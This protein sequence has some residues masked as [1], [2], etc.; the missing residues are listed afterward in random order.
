VSAEPE[1]DAERGRLR[2]AEPTL[3]VL[4]AHAAD[5]VGAVLEDGVVSELA[6]LR[7]AGVIRGGETHPM[8]AGALAAMVRPTLCTLRLSYDGRAMQGWASHDDAALLLPSREEIDERRTLLAVHPTLLPGALARL[9]GLGPRPRPRAEAPVPYED[10]ALE[11]V[12]RRWRLEAAWT[13]A[14]GA[15]GGATLEMV[16]TEGGIW[17]LQPAGDEPPLAW[18]VTPTFAWRQLVR[19]VMRRDAASA[20]T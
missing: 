17:L 16:D 15:A 10:G 2:I 14:S 6:R 13:L 7:A 18:P 11:D 9:V 12:I 19:L 3:R 20:A 5:P 8:L 1:L 4:V